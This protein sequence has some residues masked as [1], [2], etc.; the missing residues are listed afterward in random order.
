M[1]ILRRNLALFGS[2]CCATACPSD[3]EG[4]PTAAS[5]SGS[6][7]SSTDPTPATTDPT[8]GGNEDTADST[9][10]STSTGSTSSDTTSD[11]TAGNTDS[12]SSSD[13]GEPGSGLLILDSIHDVN[14]VVANK[15]LDIDADGALWIWNYNQDNLERFDDRGL[16]T[17]VASDFT[18]SF[19]TDL[20]VDSVGDI[21]VSR[22]GS[23][24]GENI[25]K[26]S[27]AGDPLWG[28]TG[29]QMRGS[30]LLGLT[31]ATVDGSEW[32]Y[33]CDGAAAG[34]Q[35]HRIDPDDG[36]LVDSIA[37]EGVPLDVAVDSAGDFFVLSSTTSNPV[38][39]GDPVLL[40]KYDDAGTVLAG[41]EMLTAAIYLAVGSNDVVYVSVSDFDEPTRSIASFD[42]DLTPRSVTPLPAEY[43]GFVGGITTVG[44]GGDLRVLIN[45][46]EG[47]GSGP[48]C[49]VLVYREP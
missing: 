18:T 6:S 5:S 36:S 48:I 39:T 4:P 12:G 21:V 44:E 3:D 41:P 49:D 9:G 26:W 37:V 8:T 42:N 45:G 19:G 43:E 2:A 47:V 30:L 40:H 16:A 13:T 46:Q 17:V 35:I 29:I 27:P 7:S 33:A 25:I 38:F 34:G 28:P 31:H 15:G 23:S 1:S 22:G 11:T 14:T 10:G 20:S 32:L 24:T